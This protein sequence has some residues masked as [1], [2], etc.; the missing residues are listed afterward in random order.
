MIGPTNPA[1]KPA[2]PTMMAPRA[3]LANIPDE[4][5]AATDA[6]FFHVNQATTSAQASEPRVAASMPR[7]CTT[8]SRNINPAVVTAITP[9]N[10]YAASATSA[11]TNTRPD[12]FI[13]ASPSSKD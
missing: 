2:A 1:T 7:P 3:T 11:V 6:V 12:V 9:A 8:A 13:S 4:F 10:S 5:D